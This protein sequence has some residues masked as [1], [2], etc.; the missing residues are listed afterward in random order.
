M[1]ARPAGAR[2]EPVPSE[3]FAAARNEALARFAAGADWILMLDPDERLDASHLHVLH[4]TPR[5]RAA[6]RER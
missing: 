6:R 1:S 2:V 4:E 3:D 5:H